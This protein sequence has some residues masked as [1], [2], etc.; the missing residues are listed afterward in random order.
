[1]CRKMY[2]F[3][4]VWGYKKGAFKQVLPSFYWI[5]S[6]PLAHTSSE[7]K[8]DKTAECFHQNNILTPYQV[9]GLII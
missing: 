8:E 5:H 7:R 3:A 2:L 6:Q 9:S 1:M 4:Y